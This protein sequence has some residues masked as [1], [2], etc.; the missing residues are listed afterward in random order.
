MRLLRNVQADHLERS[1]L[2]RRWRHALL[3][4]QHARRGAANVIAGDF[5][6]D[7]ALRDT[8]CA[9]E[10]A[11]GRDP[12]QWH[13]CRGWGAGSSGAEGHEALTAAPGASVWKAEALLPLPSFGDRSQLQREWDPESLFQTGQAHGAFAT[14]PIASARGGRTF[15]TRGS[16]V[17]VGWPSTAKPNEKV[18]GFPGQSP[19]QPNL[20]R[21]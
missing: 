12:C 15:T 5:G 19:I 16:K 21:C 14:V 18:S 10:L 1:H 3:R 6:G 13:Q 7:P 4:H 2:R 17:F 20:P 9:E 8:P 11:Q